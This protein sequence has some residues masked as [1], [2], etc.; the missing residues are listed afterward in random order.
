[1]VPAAVFS[2]DRNSLPVRQ[3][4]SSATI[5]EFRIICSGTCPDVKIPF[6]TYYTYT[7]CMQFFMSC[8]HAKHKNNRKYHNHCKYIFF[9]LERHLNIISFIHILVYYVLGSKGILP[10]TDATDCSIAPYYNTSMC[11]FVAYQFINVFSCSV[12]NL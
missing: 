4:N 1:M 11:H 10:L 5:F 12:S 6:Y 7:L 3:N 9:L 2:H 8:C